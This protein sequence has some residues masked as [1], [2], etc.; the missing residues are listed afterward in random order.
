MTRQ[1]INTGTSANDKTGDTLRASFI[2]INENFSELYANVEIIN[3]QMP[4]DISDLTDNGNL[5]T[6]GPVLS[7]Y[8]NE[9]NSPFKTDFSGASGI[10]IPYNTILEDTI[11]GFNTSTHEYTCGRTGWYSFVASTSSVTSATY[12]VQLRS[13]SGDVG[14]ATVQQ[15]YNGPAHGVMNGAAIVR[16][17]N[18]TVYQVRQLTSNGGSGDVYSGEFNTYWMLVHLR[19]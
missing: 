19:D 10:K 1:V 6:P 11:S 3:S 15:V 12:Y 13:G 7:V 2:K 17:V 5:I 16:L 14:T 8:Y 18:N 4:T 9:P